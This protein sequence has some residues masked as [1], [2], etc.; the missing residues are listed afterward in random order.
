MDAASLVPI[1]AVTL[2]VCT[3]LESTNKVRL[4][5]RRLVL[6]KDPSL[7][8][9]LL[10]RFLPVEILGKLPLDPARSTLL[11]S[12]GVHHPHVLFVT[13][14]WFV[15]VI[16]EIV[17]LVIRTAASAVAIRSAAAIE[18]VITSKFVGRVV[19]AVVVLGWDG[20]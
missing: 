13:P 15:I 19:C 16:V 12:K 5:R 2:G 10:R 17:L 1:T 7:V 18:L 8:I 4:Y 11:L 14:S 3:Y 20:R 6:L 9:F